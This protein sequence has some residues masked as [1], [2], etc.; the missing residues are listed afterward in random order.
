[1]TEEEVDAMLANVIITDEDMK[2]TLTRVVVEKKLS[3]FRWYF[4]EREN[5]PSL[6]KAYAYYEHI[7]LPRRLAGD[8]ADHIV[9]RADPGEKNKTE[10]YSVL[11]T[12]ASSFVDWGAGVDLYFSS[13]RS[14]AIMLLVCGLINIP[15]IVFYSSSAYNPKGRPG[16]V[17]IP[18]SQTFTLETSAV[19][20]TGEWAVCPNCD[21]NL[22]DN[23]GI[24][25]DG[26]MLV[27][28]SGCNG[29]QLPQGM[30]NFATALFLGISLSVMSLYQ[31]VREVRL[32]EATLTASD[33]SVEIRHP[34]KDAFDPDTWRDFFEQFA[35]KQVTCVTVALDNEKLLQKL[36][37]R[38]HLK[39]NLKASLPKNVDLDDEDFVRSAVAQIGIEE[40]QEPK[41]CVSRLIS[42]LT[43]PLEKV[44]DKLFTLTSESKYTALAFTFM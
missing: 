15:N 3:K 39:E 40:A 9:R 4:P 30:V 22:V 31:Y 12:P 37:E 5:G 17:G 34:P 41:G 24:A 32:G 36:I 43:T 28:R 27:L 26:T 8:H 16:L 11:K 6:S 10:L 25:S 1:M 20:T 44:V 7:T 18:S 2:K 42:S 29:G 33:Y 38:R 23:V 19:C 13:V 21:T 35:S 14:I